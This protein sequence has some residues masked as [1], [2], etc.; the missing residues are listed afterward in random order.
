MSNATGIMMEI[1]LLFSMLRGWG[2]GF[3][4]LCYSNH[5]VTFCELFISGPFRSS[6]ILHDDSEK[7]GDWGCVEANTESCF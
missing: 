5:Q 4:G 6:R 1:G 3:A 7:Q 2:N